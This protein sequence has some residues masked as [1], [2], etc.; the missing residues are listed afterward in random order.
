MCPDVSAVC[1]LQTRGWRTW[2]H[3]RTRVL[4]QG[5][6]SWEGPRWALALG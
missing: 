4:M 1:P 3:S 2:G 6:G 5:L